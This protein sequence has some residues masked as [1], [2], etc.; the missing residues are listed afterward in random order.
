MLKEER[1]GFLGPGNDG[2]GCEDHDVVVDQGN[3]CDVRVLE[4]GGGC[5][6]GEKFRLVLVQVVLLRRMPKPYYI[7]CYV[8]SFETCSL[9]KR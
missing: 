5:R 8:Y 9:R 6:N 1:T 4:G 7:K 2:E 3:G